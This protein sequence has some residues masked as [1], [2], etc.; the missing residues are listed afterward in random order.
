MSR[1]R[2]KSPVMGVTCARSEEDDKQ[3]YNR[4]LRRIN[5]RKLA[6]AGENAIYRNKREIMDVWSMNKD[7]KM[8]FNPEIEAKWMRK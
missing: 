3:L 4:A 8:R 2:R 1:S 5:R 7:G 6:E